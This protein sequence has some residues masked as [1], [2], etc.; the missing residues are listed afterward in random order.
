MDAKGCEEDVPLVVNHAAPGDLSVGDYVFA[1]R[2]SDCDP[3]DP[4]VVG[5][6]SEIGAGFVVVGEVTQRRWTKAMR[7]SEEQ[8]RRIIEQ[9]PIMEVNYRPQ[10]YRGIALVFGVKCGESTAEE[11]SAVWQA[12]AR[13]ADQ[14][15]EI[16]AMK[17]GQSPDDPFQKYL[18]PPVELLKK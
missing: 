14:F 18:A 13:V 1:S 9:Y 8:G 7:I 6:V 2:W 3:G 10:N 17:P 15:A 12:C 11:G 16:Q 5:H 4:W